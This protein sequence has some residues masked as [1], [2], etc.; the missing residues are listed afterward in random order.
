[1]LCRLYTFVGECDGLKNICNLHSFN[2]RHSSLDLYGKAR[3]R[4]QSFR[5][6]YTPWER[7]AGFASLFLIDIDTIYMVL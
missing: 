2:S 4:D 1:M 7:T 3:N 5:L 6:A